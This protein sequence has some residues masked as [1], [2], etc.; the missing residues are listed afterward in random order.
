MDQSIK[1]PSYVTRVEFVTSPSSSRPF[2]IKG[3]VTAGQDVVRYVVAE[4]SSPEE[5]ES[6]FRTRAA[7]AHKV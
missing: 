4:G 6:E 3:V 5:V 7:A 1:F 2:I